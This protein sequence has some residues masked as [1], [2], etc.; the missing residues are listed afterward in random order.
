MRL[1]K[2]FNINFV[3]GHERT[4][5]PLTPSVRGMLNSYGYKDKYIKEENVSRLKT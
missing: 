5:E 4:S 3:E 1:Y 2:Y